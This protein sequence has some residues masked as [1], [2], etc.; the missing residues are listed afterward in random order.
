MQEYNF[1][2]FHIPGERNVV[3]DGFS[4]LTEETPSASFVL[5]IIEEPFISVGSELVMATEE[6]VS[7]DVTA[8][9]P[10]ETADRGF[11]AHCQTRLMI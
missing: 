5:N 10:S 6:T 8:S 1:R 11:C 9:P 4:R 3:A 7:L 2:L